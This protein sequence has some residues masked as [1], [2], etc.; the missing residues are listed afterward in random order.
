MKKFKYFIYDVLDIKKEKE[1]C[2]EEFEYDSTTLVY[3][4]YNKLLK[5]YIDA[6][7]KNLD[8]YKDVVQNISF[9]AIDIIE[10]IRIS[11]STFD[12][13]FSE[14]VELHKEKTYCIIPVLPVGEVMAQYRNYKI[15]IHSNENNHLRFPH[16]HVY[17]QVR[18]SAIISLHNFE[19]TDNGIF[20]KSKD[21]KKIIEYLKNNK[22]KLIDFYNQVI[23]HKEVEKIVID[24]IL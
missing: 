15:I 8:S 11:E 3:D 21:R 6:N 12:L 1:I 4:F 23:E 9:S 13:F 24:K 20:L 16:V 19:I 7:E 14:L 5:E 17:D 22:E 18:Q 10:N 2:I